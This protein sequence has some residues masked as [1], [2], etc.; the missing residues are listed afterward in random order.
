MLINRIKLFKLV[1]LF[2]SVF[3]PSIFWIPYL[4]WLSKK[5][6]PFSEKKSMSLFID[7]NN[8]IF[9]GIVHKWHPVM[10][11]NFQLILY[12]LG[13]FMTTPKLS[14]F[15]IWK[16]RSQ[17]SSFLFSLR[18]WRNLWTTPLRKWPHSRYLWKMEWERNWVDICFVI[19]QSVTPTQDD[20]FLYFI[21]QSKN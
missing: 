13:Q 6:K 4:D 11:D 7:K 16:L 14:Y 17:K 5:F 1:F 10:F 2:Y 19:F 20:R 3:K 18:S 21:F 12:N 8:H 15:L 9:D